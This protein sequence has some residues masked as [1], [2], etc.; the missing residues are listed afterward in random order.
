MNSANGNKNRDDLL[1][2][3]TYT[4]RNIHS[5]MKLPENCKKCPSFYLLF[6]L[7]TSYFPPN[8]DIL[9][10]INLFEGSERQV[11][12]FTHPAYCICCKFPDL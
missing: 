2:G 8:L 7:K 5:K 6:S 4:P 1:H 10:Q 12:T 9:L 11:C 3:G